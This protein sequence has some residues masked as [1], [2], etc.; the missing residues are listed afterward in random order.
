MSGVAVGTT[1]FSYDTHQ[2][3]WECEFHDIVVY[4]D[5]SN[6]YAS[7]GAFQDRAQ[8]TIVHKLTHT[9]DGVDVSAGETTVLY[10][11]GARNTYIKEIIKR[12]K[13]TT[14]NSF[15]LAAT[16]TDLQQSF[17]I[18]KIT[19]YQ[20]K[21]AVRIAQLN[22]PF[23][24]NIGEVHVFP[25]HAQRTFFSGGGVY[26]V[27]S[28]PDAE[29]RVGEMH[30]WYDALNQAPATIGSDYLLRLDDDSGHF[31]INIHTHTKSSTYDRFNG[32]FAGVRAL[33]GTP[34][35][36][37]SSSIHWTA[38]V[39]DWDETLLR[40]ATFYQ[41]GEI[42]GG[43]GTEEEKLK[44]NYTVLGDN[45]HRPDSSLNSPRNMF[46]ADMHLDMINRHFG[47]TTTLGINI[48]AYL[49]I[50]VA[51]NSSTASVATMT[52]PSHVGQ[53]ATITNLD[54]GNVPYTSVLFKASIPQASLLSD[55]T[56]DIG[57]KI[58]LVAFESTSG[59]V[60]HFQQQ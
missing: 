10:N 44:F 38:H 40:E 51:G 12:G 32:Q 6:T 19:L 9:S 36:L 4:D 39:R 18:D 60:W 25:V 58:D 48:T 57:K 29:L 54:I 31:D 49:E 42:T 35:N 52:E 46:E 55:F 8:N 59:L 1:N 43:D 17:R 37:K 47:L 45:I 50:G 23:G 24:L 15:G 41:S 21:G 22:E 5:S 27:M 11:T 34:H 3:A 7:S 28:D 26:F 30:L 53:R 56:L 33:E 16:F 2:D 13:S 14:I 20:E